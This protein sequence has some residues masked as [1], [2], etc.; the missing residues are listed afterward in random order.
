MGLALVSAGG[1]ALAAAPATD[2]WTWLWQQ[3]LRAHEASAKN[4]NTDFTEVYVKNK[5]GK[6]VAGM[7]SDD[8]GNGIIAITEPQG[9]SPRAAIVVTPAGGG[10][11]AVWNSAGVLA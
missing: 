8:A 3:R 10:R 5:A 1:V 6:Q 2:Y 9:E 11:I 4:V 7:V